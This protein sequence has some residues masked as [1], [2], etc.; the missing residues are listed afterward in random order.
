MKKL[1][2]ALAAITLIALASCSDGSAGKPAT[3]VSV[4][5]GA[6]TVA[7]GSTIELLATITPVDTTDALTWS[8]TSGPGNVTIAPSSTTCVVKGVAAGAATIRA[9]AG[10]VY[11]EYTLTVPA[12]VTDDPKDSDDD[13]PITAV[14]VTGITVSPT[15][16]SLIP[17]GAI[18]LVA[19]LAPSNA[20]D[21]TV[22][23]T[24]TSGSDYATVS[25]TGLVTAKAVGV[26]K[27]QVASVADPTKTAETI[28]TVTDPVAATGVTIADESA[29]VYVGK[30][31]YLT[32]AVTPA[33]STDVPT[34]SIE[35]GSQY[36]SVGTSGVITGLAEGSA[37][38]KVTAGAFSDTIAITVKASYKVDFSLNKAT[39][40]GLPPAQYVIPGETVVKPTDPTCVGFTFTGWYVDSAATVQ[41][42]FD[43][44]PTQALTLHAGWNPLPVQDD[45]LSNAIALNLGET[46]TGLS[47]DSSTD[48]DWYVV[49]ATAGQTYVVTI[50]AANGN[51]NNGARVYASDGS[52]KINE[53][54]G[55]TQ[56]SFAATASGNYFI[57]T[58]YNSALQGYSIS[59]EQAS[60][61]KLTIPLNLYLSSLKGLTLQYYLLPKKDSLLSD[62][63]ATGSCTLTGTASDALTFATTWAGEGYVLAIVDMDKNGLPSKDDGGFM[64][65]VVMNGD[66]TLNQNEMLFSYLGSNEYDN[67]LT[68]AH[69]LA[70]NQIVSDATLFSVTDTD[71]YKVTLE[72]GK[73]YYLNHYKSDNSGPT[74][75][76]EI[77]DSSYNWVTTV[78]NSTTYRTSYVPSNSGDYIIKINCI[79]GFGEYT[80]SVSDTD[81]GSIDIS[82]Q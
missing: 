54:Y 57:E 42:S 2:A 75:N 9:T 40:Q 74:M 70:V 58:F 56:F 7:I 49:Q 5:A 50:T 55:F 77:F 47:I 4:T 3:A 48:H 34:W 10:S 60:K 43:T 23:W 22:T 80:L 14:P 13:D 78:Q 51:Y 1:I 8:I 39:A 15:A 21:K 26:A 11:G 6:A 62:A 68:L 76:I 16:Q 38:V 19:T 79:A 41:F 65:Y 35:S 71:C 67:N 24:V 27:I 36:L 37:V 29:S 53:K 12:A 44:A 17:G 20:T 32:A 31:A 64:T 69:P 73:T 52:T 33:T 66:Y 59:V 46:L 25:S 82:Y 18:Q 81:T 30:T 28:I 63:I 45:T 61:G 72:A